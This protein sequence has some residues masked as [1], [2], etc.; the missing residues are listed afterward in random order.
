MS[1]WDTLIPQLQTKLVFL[2]FANQSC[3]FSSACLRP[4]RV[5]PQVL[6]QVLNL[7]CYFEFAIFLKLDLLS[8]T[9]NPYHKFYPISL[10]L[11]LSL[12]LLFYHVQSKI[13]TIT[14]FK[15]FTIKDILRVNQFPL[16]A[17]SIFIFCLKI[18][19]VIWLIYCRYDSQG[20]V[21]ILSK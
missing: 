8:S 13:K 3:F 12:S 20:I 11:S 10:S 2:L 9:L 7:S 15:Q 17:K 16:L 14:T 1:L 18:Y 6:K 19:F 4:K 21:G 5:V